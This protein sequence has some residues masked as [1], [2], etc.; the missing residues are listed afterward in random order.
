MQVMNLC[1]TY[2][3]LALGVIVM[4]DRR[5][6]LATH[7]GH[8]LL[9]MLTLFWLFRFAEQFIFFSFRSVFSKVLTVMFA[10]GIAIYS[11]PLVLE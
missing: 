11:L 7:L 6:I 8:H 9:F 4:L 10:A 2:L 5:E 1:L 3:F